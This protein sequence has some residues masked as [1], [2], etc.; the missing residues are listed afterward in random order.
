MKKLSDSQIRML[1]NVR[2]HGDPFRGVSGLSASGGA[3]GT[4]VSLIRRDLLQRVC[5]NDKPEW[6]LTPAGLT[7]IT[8][9]Q[10]EPPP[11]NPSEDFAASIETLR[12]NGLTSGVIVSVDKRYVK[13][14]RTAESV[15][16]NTLTLAAIEPTSVPGSTVTLTC[17]WCDEGDPFEGIPAGPVCDKPAT[18]LSCAPYKDAPTCEA[19]K[20]RCARTL[21]E[22]RPV[23]GLPEGT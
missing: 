2:D 23:T 7:A 22:I 14:F 19:H 17:A 18:H 16:G 6:Q 3:T 9:V 8:S 5:V 4:L 15:A 1:S 13:T 11:Y 10:P 21:N 12:L 20:C